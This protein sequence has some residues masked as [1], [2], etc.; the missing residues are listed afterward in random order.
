MVNSNENIF[1]NT[2]DIVIKNLGD[3]QKKIL[4]LIDRIKSFKTNVDLEIEKKIKA[5]IA[6]DKERE[7]ILDFHEMKIESALSNVQY[8]ITEKEV[9]DKL[10][11]DS[12]SFG[13]EVEKQKILF[14][15]TK[16]RFKLEIKNHDKALLNFEDKS[17]NIQSACDSYIYSITE[18]SLIPVLDEIKDIHLTSFSNELKNKGAEDLNLISEKLDLIV[19]GFH[20]KNQEIAT[21]V[22]EK[23]NE[24]NSLM[25]ILKNIRIEK[26]DFLEL[27]KTILETNQAAENNKNQLEEFTKSLEIKLN[28]TKEEILGFNKNCSGNIL[29]FKKQAEDLQ[30]IC[31]KY[32]KSI[33]RQNFELVLNNLRSEQVEIFSNALSVISENELDKCYN[34]I[35]IKQDELNSFLSVYDKKLGQLR[36]NITDLDSVKNEFLAIKKTV[37]FQIGL[38]SKS[39]DGFKQLNNEIK[40]EILVSRLDFKKEHDSSFLILQEVQNKIINIQQNLEVY[41]YSKLNE[42]LTSHTERIINTKANDFFCKLESFADDIFVKKQ[43]IFEINLNELFI[44]IEN[45]ETRVSSLVENLKHI[46]LFNDKI[47]AFNDNF[48]KFSLGSA[49]VLSFINDF[50]KAVREEKDKLDLLK[51][52]LILF[53]LNLKSETEKTIQDHV[54]KGA[55]K[56]INEFIHSYEVNIDEFCKKVIA[57]N[58]SISKE[59]LVKEINDYYFE[60]SY[61]FRKEVDEAK[62][63]I[64]ELNKSSKF[65]LSVLSLGFLLLFISSFIFLN[66]KVNKYQE[67]II[68]SSNTSEDLTS[69]I[70]TKLLMI[71]RKTD[72][73]FSITKFMDADLQSTKK[74]ILKDAKSK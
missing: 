22:Q 9:L 4:E 47:N 11:N 35:I 53:S 44:Q 19:N 12:K 1:S 41:I 36:S 14:E 51:S 17:K 48:N 29:E 5:K 3:F 73:L 26:D 24:I 67:Q 46:E 45:Q 57:K 62:I 71:E 28:F 72:N 30:N 23:Q 39:V 31:D 42:L 63:K 60:Y 10:I 38:V 6:F 16:K 21:E 68:K 56:K 33:T 49:K 69:S 18:K 34:Y 27:N 54:Q 43:K 7:K 59:K 52:D 32:I 37:D 25:V 55:F 15:E 8:L 58:I 61:K 50:R 65:Y 70:N 74:A 40:N 66:Y 13:N 2:P 64:N 20:V